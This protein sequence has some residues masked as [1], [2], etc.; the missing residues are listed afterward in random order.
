[1]PCESSKRKS[2]VVKVTDIFV[3]PCAGVIISQWRCPWMIEAEIMVITKTHTAPSL[4]IN[5][6]YF[7]TL[8]ICQCFYIQCFISVHF[9]PSTSK[10]LFHLNNNFKQQ[11][12]NRLMVVFSIHKPRET[13]CTISLVLWQT[14]L[15]HHVM[16]VM[17]VPVGCLP[18]HRHHVKE[19]YKES[20]AL[21][22]LSFKSLW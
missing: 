18:L 6:Q 16:V 4:S 2:R 12:R 19:I 8:Q 1:M 7:T 17:T 20:A 10:L 5:T 22:V 9:L 21:Y 13:V 14:S 11:T 15:F 3:I